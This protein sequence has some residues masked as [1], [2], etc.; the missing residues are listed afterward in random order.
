MNLSVNL[1]SQPFRRDRPM[2][3]ASAAAGVLLFAV[4][5][6]LV[7]LNLAERKRLA[8]SRA[9]IAKL[10]RQLRVIAVEQ[11]KLDAVLRK[12]ENAQVLDRGV[13][14]NTTIHRQG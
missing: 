8:A 2:L 7:F 4:L 12:P 6:L 11:A 5:C 3:I 1:A 10:E 14:V 13:L 9:D